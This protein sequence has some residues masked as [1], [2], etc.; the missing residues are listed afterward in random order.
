LVDER[1]KNC[2]SLNFKKTATVF[3]FF[4][5]LISSHHSTMHFFP[6]R[7]TKNDRFLSFGRFKKEIELG[8]GMPQA[9]SRYTNE[10]F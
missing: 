2:F 9:R 6:Y 7:I 10:D 3:G 5:R 8:L 1:E 4:N